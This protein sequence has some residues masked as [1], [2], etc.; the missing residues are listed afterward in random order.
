M[1]LPTSGP[2]SFT[3]INTEFNRGTNLQ[4]YR[5][6]QWWTQ[7]TTGSFST[8]NIKFS[9]FYGKRATRPGYYLSFNFQE[10]VW[11][12]SGI[13]VAGGGFQTYEYLSGSKSFPEA[14]NIFIESIRIAYTGTGYPGVYVKCTE[15]VSN[16]PGVAC[17]VRFTSVS[18]GSVLYDQTTST[19]AT[20]GLFGPIF[21]PRGWPP[22]YAMQGSPPDAD[23]MGWPSP[24]WT[25]EVWI[26]TV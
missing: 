12:R 1:T 16:R 26:Y 18:S 24:G 20:T 23:G 6:V 15:S 21:L 25:T 10:G 7:T 3:A 9:E 2:L 8:N 14:P 5:G 22:C 11:Q 19:Y 13:L 17:R 4:A